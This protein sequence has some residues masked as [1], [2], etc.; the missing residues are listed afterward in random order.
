M[1]KIKTSAL[2]TD[3]TVLNPLYHP[4]GELIHPPGERITGA[5][6]YLLQRLGI[7]EVVELVGEKEIQRFIFLAEHESISIAS[8]KLN[9]GLSFDIYDENGKII[10]RKGHKFDLEQKDILYKKGFTDVYRPKQAEEQSISAVRQYREAVA[11]LN[12]LESEA[13][14]ISIDLSNIKEFQNVRNKLTQEFVEKQIERMNLRIAPSGKTLRGHI[15]THVD[16]MHARTDVYKLAHSSVVLNTVKEINNIFKSISQGKSVRGEIIQNVSREII[17]CIVRDKDF[18]LNVANMRAA[19]DYLLSHSVRVAVLAT[20]IATSMGYNPEQVLEISYGAFLHDIGM[21]KVPR[22]ILE[23]NRKLS[24]EERTEIE[25]HPLYGVT[26]LQHIM[27]FPQSTPFIAYQSHERSDGTGYPS[28]RSTQLIHDYAKIVAIADIY[29]ALISERPYR[30]ALIPYKAMEEII[31]L[32]NKKRVDPMVV[33]AF[34]NSTSLFPIGSWVEITDGRKGKVIATSAGEN[35]KP[36]VCILYNH[37][38]K[39]VSM[40]ERMDL[41]K[42]PELKVKK[43]IDGKGMD[44][45]LTDGF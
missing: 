11:A 32:A 22:V 21:L 13:Q 14:N 23:R 38:G 31:F 16:P 39:P 35:T 25:K 2:N 33:K 7:D 45:S 40:P 26:L 3:E 34:L 1:R 30:P 8:I 10:L 4:N 42:Y 19:D 18:L 29:D 36:V 17:K 44:V 20:A 24:S 41:R 27:T 28:R 43:A 15:N 12:E 9:E 5:H 37:E 6:L